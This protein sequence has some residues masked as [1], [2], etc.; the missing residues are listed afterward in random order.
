MALL[1]SLRQ[2]RQRLCRVAPCLCRGLTMT[3]KQHK[4]R[5]RP[6]T[7]FFN[8]HDPSTASGSTNIKFK[9]VFTPTGKQP[10]R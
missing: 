1:C 7:V 8:G 10:N 5:I 3:T 6:T 9:M 2:P 4:T